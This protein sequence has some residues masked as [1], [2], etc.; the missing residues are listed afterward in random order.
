MTILATLYIYLSAF[1]LQM[2]LYI[3]V[4]AKLNFHRKNRIKP[5]I[6]EPVSVIICARNEEKNLQKNLPL[7]LNQNYKTFEVIVVNDA[8][9]DNSKNV[10]DELKKKYN[11]LKVLTIS[12][13]EKKTDGKKQALDLAIWSSKY[14]WLLLTDADCTPISPDWIGLMADNFTS[15]KAIVLGYS[16]YKK[17]NSFVNWFIRYDTFYT[18]LQYFSFTL[19]K[20]PYMGVGRNMAYR[21]SLYINS[22]GFKNHMQF[23][24]GDDDLFVN[25]V[26]DKNNT[27][28]EISKDSFMISEPKKTFMELIIQKKRHLGAGKYYKNN[29]KIVLGIVILSQF[30][31]YYGFCVLLIISIVKLKLILMIF[32][33]RYFVQLIVLIRISKLLNES[34]LFL[35]FLPLLEFL[36]LAFEI[37]VYFSN[38]FIPKYKWR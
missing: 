2:G 18:A 22:E 34:I 14:E 19:N 3:L 37:L 9:E 23:I 13:E 6:Q 30:L 5:E 8:S 25:Q 4:F 15:N 38:L 35:L 17:N 10:L 29:H 33:V 1:V 26:A 7:I 36:Y 28:I 11:H 12:K 16:P 24:C 27:V 31:F 32:I 21:K 20:M